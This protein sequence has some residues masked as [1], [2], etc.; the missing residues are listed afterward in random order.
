[1]EKCWFMLFVLISIVVLPL[2]CI[3]SL[4]L[5]VIRVMNPERI[6]LIKDSGKTIQG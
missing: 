6:T 4:L 1:M 3:S 2:V 5:K